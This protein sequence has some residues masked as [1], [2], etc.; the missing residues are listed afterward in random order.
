MRLDPV[1]GH[2]THPQI[3]IRWHSN[4]EMVL[5]N[6]PHPGGDLSVEANPWG[7]DLDGRSQRIHPWLKASHGVLRGS[8]SCKWT[9]LGDTKNWVS[10]DFCATPRLTFVALAQ[11]WTYNWVTGS[12]SLLRT[13]TRIQHLRRHNQPFNRFILLAS[14]KRSIHNIANPNQI[15][16]IVSSCPNGSL[17]DSMTPGLSWKQR[18]EGNVLLSLPLVWAE[19]CAGVS[20]YFPCFRKT[21]YPQNTRNC[22]FHPRTR[23]SW[24]AFQ[25]TS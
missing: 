20:R 12:L 24:E 25:T 16:C 3:P 6:L 13:S 7:T 11:N 4:T 17:N 15:G 8:K 5:N 21:F 9:K 2:V 18:K 1:P 19:D 14:F 23:L 10:I 22:Q